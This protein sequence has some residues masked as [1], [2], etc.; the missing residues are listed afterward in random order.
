MQIEPMPRGQI[1]KPTV[2]TRVYKMKTALYNGQHGDKGGE[3]HDGAH[4]AYNKVLDMLNEFS[5]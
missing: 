5:G 2:L 3:W 4:D 1:D